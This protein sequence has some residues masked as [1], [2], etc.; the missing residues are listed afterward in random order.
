VA[1]EATTEQENSS[2]QSVPIL[3][4]VL[5]LFLLSGFLLNR[6]RSR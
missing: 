1:I 2:N 4:G 5:A 3:L 6:R